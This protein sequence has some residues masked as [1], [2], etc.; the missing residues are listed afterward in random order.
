AALAGT[1]AFQQVAGEKLHVRADALGIDL[2]HSRNGIGRQI[3]R[4]AGTVF[5]LCLCSGEDRNRQDQRERKDA[6]MQAAGSW[7]SWM[8][9][10]YFTVSGERGEQYTH[11]SAFLYVPLVKL[12]AGS[13]RTLRSLRELCG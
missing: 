1:T 4:G 8:N 7:S 6:F 5:G 2:L 11:C 13:L 12:L 10:D 9:L 3:R